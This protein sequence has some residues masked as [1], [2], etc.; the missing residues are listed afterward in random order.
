MTTTLTLTAYGID[1]NNSGRGIHRRFPTGRAWKGENM[2]SICKALGIESRRQQLELKDT[3]SI[4]NMLY[5][6]NLERWEQCLGLLGEGTTAEREQA[7]SRKLSDIGGLKA[8]DVERELQ[9]AGFNLYVY[10]N[11]FDPGTIDYTKFPSTFGSAYFGSDYFSETRRYLSIN[12]YFFKDASPLPGQ[13]FGSAFFGSKTFGYSGAGTGAEL[14]ARGSYEDDL[15]LWSSL[16]T[17]PME[18]YQYSFF[19]AGASWGDIADVDSDRRTE[20]RRLI[21]EIKPMG[22]WA[23]GFINY[24]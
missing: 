15:L 4:N 5:G 14:F 7:V 18:R 17:A 10:E 21:M 22:M 23:F 12:P 2:L 6:D 13:T 24:I 20:L 1:D 11:R 9:A 8:S 19:I 16:L 3:A